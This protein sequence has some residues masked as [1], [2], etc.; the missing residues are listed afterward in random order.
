[1]TIG[2]TEVLIILGLVLLLFGSARLPGLARSL[3]QASNEFKAGSR[4]GAGGADPET[5]DAER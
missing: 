4:E 1:M 3:G 2:A 5:A